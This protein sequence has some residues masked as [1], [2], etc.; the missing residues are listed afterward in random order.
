MGSG[1]TADELGRR[2][3][4]ERAKSL[5]V[6]PVAALQEGQMIHALQF[7][8]GSGIFA[9]EH[10]FI[11]EVAPITD[12]TAIPCAPR[13][14]RG[15]VNA[16][17][18]IVS[19]LCLKSILG[20]AAGGAE[21]PANMVILESANAEFGLMADE[22]LGFVAMPAA[23]VQAPPPTLANV[24]GAYVKGVTADGI[25]LLDAELLLSDKKLVV[26]EKVESAL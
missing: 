8:L 16:R 14:V 17:G 26:N 1:E 10:R 5:A 15:V 23:S 3:L 4:H 12:I 9:I 24:R 19:L 18:R 11:R 25:V 6:V 21:T 13:F 7:L 22:I 2:I 20:M